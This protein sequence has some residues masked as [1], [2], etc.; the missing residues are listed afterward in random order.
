MSR[1]TRPTALHTTRKLPAAA[2]A[3]ALCLGLAAQALAQ[4]AAPAPAQTIEVTGIR[5]SIMK[6]IATKRNADTN[7]EA[8]TAEDVGKMPDKNIADAL[9][10]LPGVNVQYGGALALDEAERV[11]IRGMSPNLNLITINGHALSSGDWHVGDQAGSGRSVGFGLM[12]SQLIGQ[13]IVYKTSRADITEGGI[14]GSVD[15]ITRKPL[16]FT[17]PLSG[18]VS[19]GLVHAALAKKTDPQVSGLIAWKN[20][21]NTFGVLGQFFKED[22]HLRRD[23][24][25]IFGYNVVTTAQA[26]ASGNPALAGKRLTGSLNSAMFEG[27]RERSGGYVGLQFKPNQDLELNA[28]AFYSKLNAE[29]YN[30]S[31]YA[32][33]YGLVNNAG[34]L[35]QNAVITGDTITKANIVRPTGSTANVVGL[36]FDHF[37]RQGAESI[38]S[39]YDIDGKWN[40]LPSLTLK[41]R[42]GYTEGS[43]T[44]ASQPSLVYGLLNPQSVNFSQTQ[45]APAEYNIQNAS[46][47]NIDLTK[48]AN[49]NMLTNQGAAVKAVDKENY[50][51]FDGDFKADW[52]VLTNVKF[53]ARAATHKR[54]YAVVNPRWN[55]QDD[56]NGPIPTTAANYPFIPIAGGTLIKTTT[57]PDSARPTPATVYPGNWFNGASGNFPRELFRFNADQMKAFTDQYINWDPVLNR[58]L[59]GGFEVKEQNTAAYVMGE[60]EFM[61]SLSGNAGVRLVQTKLESVSYQALTSG[62]GVGQCVVLQPC[63]VPGAIVGSRVATYVQRVVN[64]TKNDTLPSLNL[65]WDVDKDLIARF[66]LSRSLGRANYN[67]LAGAVT[68]ND[69]LLT[70]SSGNPLLKPITSDNVDLSL[71]WYFAPRAYVSGG[72]FAQELRNYV[73]TGVSAIDYFNI[74]QN[75]ITTYA[76]TSRIGVGAKVSGVEAALELPVGAGFGLNING[77]YVNSKDDDGAPLLGTSKFTYNLRG[78]YES[79]A[80][81]ASLAWNYR[82]DYAIGFVGN[83]TLQPIVNNLGVITQYNG[84]HRYA[85][86]G[87]LSLSLGYKFTKDISLHFDGNNLNDPIRHT[88]YINKDAPGYWHQNGRQYFL[89]L[90]AKI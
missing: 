59:S 2:A 51:H 27:V 36:Q 32:L 57:L 81:S 84:Q 88:Y 56:A 67:E 31:G 69:T 42:V 14:S 23:G 71:A 37:K 5:A 44:T 50:F 87:A 35:I 18:E 65:R 90:R 28:S 63:A 7:I 55:A 74:A 64:T 30:S 72:V 40:V 26:T 46:G 78:F 83:G 21:T 70:G 66:A 33:P 53:G 54:T 43:G 68:L 17:K 85:A 1:K 73:K 4:T 48:V 22:R 89:T 12:P 8:V 3:S 29:N 6:S 11:A 25:E 47:T 13:S 79:D 41:A 34:Y 20:D 77:T 49:F 38:S 75:K 61:P 45:G 58:N 80:F 60:F 19:L 9:S 86:G 52:S 39:F 62:T 15:I 16:D 24:Q 76:V 10:R 82:T